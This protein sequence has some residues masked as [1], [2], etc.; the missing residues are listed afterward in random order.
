MSDFLYFSALLPLI[1]LP[2]SPT[3]GKGDE[4]RSDAWNERGCGLM[5]FE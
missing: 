3:R 4:G 2:P 5:V 1:P